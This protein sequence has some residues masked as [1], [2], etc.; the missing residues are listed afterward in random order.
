MQ[1]SGCS[2]DSPCGFTWSPFNLYNLRKNPE[3]YANILRDQYEEQGRPADKMELSNILL[4]VKAVFTGNACFTLVDDKGVQFLQNGRDEIEVEDSSKMW[5][6]GIDTD[7][8]RAI[9]KEK[10]CLRLRSESDIFIDT[11][12]APVID[13]HAD[14]IKATQLFQLLPP[15]NYASHEPEQQQASGP[16]SSEAAPSTTTNPTT[17]A[18]APDI[19]ALLTALV[20]GKLPDA[21]CPPQQAAAA[22]SVKPEAPTPKSSQGKDSQN[23]LTV[24]SRVNPYI[25]PQRTLDRPRYS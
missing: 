6:L 24:G 11:K 21:G 18:P 1:T 25:R 4:L 16:S 7:T 8:G 17:T 3:S 10:G 14:K 9:L 22:P 23:L 15:S 5:V 13:L 2:F 20:Q 19:M 12:L